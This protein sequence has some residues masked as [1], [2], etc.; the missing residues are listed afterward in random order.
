[1]ARRQ[2]TETKNIPAWQITPAPVL[3]A[4]PPEL[5]EIDVEE[6]EK[7]LQRI[8]AESLGVKR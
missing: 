1:M 2:K 5:P 3:F 8:W 7:E 4:N 6:Q